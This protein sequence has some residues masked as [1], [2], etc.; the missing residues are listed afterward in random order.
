[1]INTNGSGSGLISDHL[2]DDKVTNSED[3]GS[4]SSVASGS[5]SCS[6]NGIGP[7]ATSGSSSGSI[8]GIGSNNVSIIS[9]NSVNGGSNDV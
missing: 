1:M 9:S 6:V 3:N 7:N 8:S 5:S 4:G 2:L